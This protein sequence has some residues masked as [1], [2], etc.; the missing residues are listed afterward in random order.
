MFQNNV[1]ISCDFVALFCIFSIDSLGCVIPI[2]R[3]HN[4]T[5]NIHMYTVQYIDN[6][7]GSV[8]SYKTKFP[9]LFTHHVAQNST[10]SNI[11]L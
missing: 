2:T 5:Y 9:I 8:S 10:I 6:S 4:Y 7:E 3:V 1:F 11:I